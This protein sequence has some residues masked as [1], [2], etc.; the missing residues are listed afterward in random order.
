[1]FNIKFVTNLAK[2]A[3]TGEEELL[4]NILQK[5]LEGMGQSLIMSYLGGPAGTASRIQQAVATGGQSEFDRTRDQFLH[6]LM[7]SGGRAGGVARK[8]GALF[9]ASGRGYRGRGHGRGRAGSWQASTWAAS[10]QDWLD[11]H[12]HHDW[13]S[14][15][16][17]EHGRWIPGRLDYIAAQFQYRGKPHKGRTVLRRRK[18]RR[19]RRLA[20][21]RE[22]KKMLGKGY[23]PD[24][25]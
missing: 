18:R 14:Q 2:A 16:R 15:P 17:D 4:E 25:H 6:S 24:G 20:T 12:W 5:K 19:L 11:N 21:K 1:M 8:I 3:F 10:R 13:R 23:P 22:L 7:P 9:D